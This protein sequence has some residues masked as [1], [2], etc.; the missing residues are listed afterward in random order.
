LTNVL[1]LGNMD[2]SRDWGHS[3]D[4]V[5][6]MHKIVNHDVADEFI[7]AT[8][9]SHTVRELCNVVFNKLGMNY[10][11]Y[12]VQNPKFMR[13]EELR[14]LR[15]DPSKAMDVLGWKPEYTFETMLDEMIERWDKEL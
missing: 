1:E 15:G 11:D 2:S 7:V 12:V 10:H 5:R 9:E 8:G 6:A 14:Y 4:Y 13:P 3:K